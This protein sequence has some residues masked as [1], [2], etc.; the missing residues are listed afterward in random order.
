M[1]VFLRLRAGQPQAQIPSDAL[2]LA[3]HL[4]AA[5]RTPRTLLDKDRTEAALGPS[6]DDGPATFGPL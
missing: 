1:G 2:S 5:A 4:G 3:Q 6:R